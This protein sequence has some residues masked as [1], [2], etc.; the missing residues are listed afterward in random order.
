MLHLLRAYA[1][2]RRRRSRAEISVLL[3]LRGNRLLDDVAGPARVDLHA[4]A[5]RGADHDR[6]QVATLGGRWL[7]AD[8]LLDHGR[9][10]LEQAPRLE[11][12]LA[13]HEVDDRVAV[14]AVL[15]LAR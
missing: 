9:V 5:H 3:S 13:D 4:R 6:V 10:V 2:V 12:A 8:Q 15:D 7:G 14:G 1:T 11:V